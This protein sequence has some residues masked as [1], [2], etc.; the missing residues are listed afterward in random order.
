MLDKEGE[1]KS[2]LILM[3]SESV[4]TS[5]VSLYLCG[6]MKEALVDLT[7]PRE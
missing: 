1:G 4:I 6:R 3:F 5:H 2:I 7:L